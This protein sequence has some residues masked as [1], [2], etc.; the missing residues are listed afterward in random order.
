MSAYRVKV[1]TFF[2]GCL[3]LIMM[4]N[5]VASHRLRRRVMQLPTNPA[6]VPSA[7]VFLSKFDANSDPAQ[8]RE[9]ALRE[10]R[11]LIA[12]ESLINSYGSLLQTL[13]RNVLFQSWCVLIIAIC[14]FLFEYRTPR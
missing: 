9:I 7:E 1:P 8:L 12:A 14:Y 6:L 2:L 4:I 10:H 11:R 5:L 3:L 13:S